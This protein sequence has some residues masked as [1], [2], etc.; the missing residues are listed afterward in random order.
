MSQRQRVIAVAAFFLLL[1]AVVLRWRPDA[2]AG[3]AKRPT[4]TQPVVTGG[5]ASDCDEV[6][7]DPQLVGNLGPAFQSTGG[8]GGISCVIRFP[9][10]A[11]FVQAMRLRATFRCHAIA[12]ELH[13]RIPPRS[14]SW[15]FDRQSTLEQDEGLCVEEV[16]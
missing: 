15:E 13:L 1:G 3:P 8:A 4:S 16:A 6:A 12:M 11:Q 10:D 2:P 7:R 5:P 14:R 9:H